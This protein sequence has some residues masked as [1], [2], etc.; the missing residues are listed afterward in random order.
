MSHGQPKKPQAGHVPIKYGDVFSAS[1]AVE[2]GQVLGNR[3]E[4]HAPVVPTGIGSAAIDGDPITIGDA[5]EA[6]A[7]SVGDKPVDQN[8]AAAISA[9]EIRATGEKKV[10]SGGVGEMAQAA[11]TLNSHFM[12]VQDMTKLSDILTDA[13]EKLP[14]DKAVTKEDAEAVYAAEVQ[15]PW[16]RDA[17]VIAESGGVAASMATAAN[18][19]EL[20]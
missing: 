11:A 5:L 6:V 2:D 19:N 10:R 16:R 8:D 14:V 1:S 7:I 18:L 20:K 3:V 12:R 17:E 13:T 4:P 15:F 9:A